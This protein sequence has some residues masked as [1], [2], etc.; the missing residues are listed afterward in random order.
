MGILERGQVTYLGGQIQQHVTTT[1]QRGSMIF[2][3]FRDDIK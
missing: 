2:G 3:A 1:G